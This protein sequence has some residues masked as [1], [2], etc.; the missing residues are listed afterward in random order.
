M[1]HVGVAVRGQ[2]DDIRG[3]NEG[4]TRRCAVGLRRL[5]EAALAETH[6]QTGAAASK[7]FVRA[8]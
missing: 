3:A 8:P 1:S 4:T 7:T 2:I 5:L 6:I